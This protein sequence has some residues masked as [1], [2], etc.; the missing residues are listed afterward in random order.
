M[1]THK[2]STS[3]YDRFR[4]AAA[5]EMGI[6]PASRKRP[7]NTLD[8]KTVVEAERWRT[9]LIKDL[10]RRIEKIHEPGLSDGQLRDVN[11]DINNKLRIKLQWVRVFDLGMHGLC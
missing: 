8:T 9:E 4:D 1:A 3:I 7:T 10:T 11:D 2:I 5:E 6:R